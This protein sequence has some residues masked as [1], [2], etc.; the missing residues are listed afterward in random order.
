MGAKFTSRGLLLAAV[1]AIACLPVQAQW[2]WRDARGQVQYSDRPPP[3]GTPERDILQ[4]PNAAT[5]PRTEPLVEA[6]SAPAPAA[7]ASAVDPALEAKRKQAEQEEQA[8]RKAEEERNLQAKAQNCA[9]ARSAMRTLESGQRMV[10]INDKGEREVIDDTI[11]AAE[12]QQARQVA[13]ENC[14]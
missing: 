13:T 11:R 7:A 3:S 6:A 5:L 4:R 8:K 2:K 14:S 10:R 9:R 12:M 1:L